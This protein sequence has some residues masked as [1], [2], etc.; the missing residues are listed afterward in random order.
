MAAAG[1][2]PQDLDDEPP[3]GREHDLLAV[4]RWVGKAAAGFC[5][6]GPV[7]ALEALD[8]VDGQSA[9]A[10]AG[11]EGGAGVRCVKR[12]GSEPRRLEVDE[13]RRAIRVEYPVVEAGVAVDQRPPVLTFERPDLQLREV[14]AVEGQ[15]DPALPSASWMLSAR[16]S[17]GRDVRG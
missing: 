8:N 10:P 4:R 9:Q 17:R 11:R 7:S 12:D 16:V 13:D 6:R 15:A 14:C 1:D 3:R 5:E 2:T